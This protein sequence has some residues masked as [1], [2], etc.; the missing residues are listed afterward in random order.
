MR[1][2]IIVIVAVNQ[3]KYLSANIWITSDDKFIINGIIIPP[4]KN[5]ILDFNFLKFLIFINFLI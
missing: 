2:N 3:F 5:K 1:G 4:A